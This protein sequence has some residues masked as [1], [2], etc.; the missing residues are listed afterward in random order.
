MKEEIFFQI[1]DKE[2][3]VALECTEPTAI[4]LA[5]KIY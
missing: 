1:L 4:A 3:V 2:L 5:A